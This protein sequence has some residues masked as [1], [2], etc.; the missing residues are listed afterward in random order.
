M[1]LREWYDLGR[2]FLPSKLFLPVYS[3]CF[4]L[5]LNGSY[6][7]GT[8]TH[9]HRQQKGQ[10]DRQKSVPKIFILASTNLPTEK[11]ILGKFSTISKAG[12]PG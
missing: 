11:H 9:T 1:R 5:P 4:M 3:S 10:I 12:C 2:H 6:L 7:T 8:H